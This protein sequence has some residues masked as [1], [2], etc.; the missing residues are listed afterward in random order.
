MSL[1]TATA[2]VLVEYKDV[3]KSCPETTSNMAQPLHLRASPNAS[4]RSETRLAESISTV[5]VEPS[6]K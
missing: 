4:I 2:T 1:H 5:F 3:Q 6:G